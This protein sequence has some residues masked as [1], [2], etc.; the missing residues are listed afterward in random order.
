MW[1]VLTRGVALRIRM[2][3]TS[4]FQRLRPCAMLG[5]KRVERGRR[6]QV[7]GVGVWVVE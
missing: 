5:G 6:G 4:G 2:R 3:I 1:D 7:D